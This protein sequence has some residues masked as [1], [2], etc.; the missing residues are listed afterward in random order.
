MNSYMDFLRM[1]GELDFLHPL[2]VER[3]WGVGPATARK[4][5]AEA[6]CEPLDRADEVEVLGLA[7]EGD[8]VPAA[9]AAEDITKRRGIAGDF[10]VFRC[11]G[12]VAELLWW[13]L[14]PMLR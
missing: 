2:P 14:P 10:T 6:L 7:D 12:A 11:A 1:E 5:H 13:P 9:A 8:D 3:L 4:L